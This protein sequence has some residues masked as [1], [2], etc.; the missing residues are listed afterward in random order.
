MKNWRRPAAILVLVLAVAGLSAYAALSGRGAKEEVSDA[1][2]VESETVAPTTSSP[3]TSEAAPTPPASST[4]PAAPRTKAPGPAPEGMVWIPG[5]S[6]IMG[7]DD[8]TTKDALPVHKVTLDGFFIDRSEVTNKQ[9]AAF[10][11]DTGYLT[12]AERAP[13]PKDFPGAPKELLVPGSLV[14][15]PPAGKVSLENHYIWWSYVPGASWKHPEG[16]G[17][18]IDG[19]DDHPVVHVCWDDAA[20]YCRWAGKRLPTEAEWEYAAR[21]GLDQKRYV[22]GDKLM[23][24]GKWLVNNWQGDFPSQNTA[25]DGYVKTAPVGTFAP[26]G[27][28]LSDMA[29]NVWEW[30]AD[31]YKPG[32]DASKE[33]DPQGPDSSYDPAEPQ[34]PKRVQ[35][36]GSF[37]CSDLYCTRYLP[38]ARGKGATDS[39]TNHTGFR[40][41]QT[42]KRPPNAG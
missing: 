23:P 27:Y 6:F 15:T 20:A 40:C 16:P 28:G 13:D 24:D 21:G 26:N 4:A 32:Y 39:G 31:W 10:V 19:K 22:W 8:P 36:G 17:S 34:I 9:F 35:R 7:Y 42:P 33:R 18:N 14:F 11:K 25:S 2:V 29:G 1:V 41:V 30:C 5:G 37:L 38:G 3:P 12:V